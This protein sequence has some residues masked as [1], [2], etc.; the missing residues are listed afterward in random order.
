MKT[1]PR[2]ATFLKTMM[3]AG[4]HTIYPSEKDEREAKTQPKVCTV[5]VV[6]V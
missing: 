2:V 4:T 3:M 6:I 5:V 1:M